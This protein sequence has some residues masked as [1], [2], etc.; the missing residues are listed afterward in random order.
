MSKKKRNDGRQNRGADRQTNKPTADAI[1][2]YPTDETTAAASPTDKIVDPADSPATVAA[3]A[4]AAEDREDA[5]D[6]DDAGRGGG[7]R[8]D[9]DR[10]GPDDDGGPPPP[11]SQR[12]RWLKYGS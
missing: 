10:D 11:E 9:D 1:K 5:L 12:E 8:D 3:A 2:T 6:R 4:Q 7:G